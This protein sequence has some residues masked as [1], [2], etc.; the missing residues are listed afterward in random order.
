MT[1]QNTTPQSGNK[2]G[3]PTT[4]NTPVIPSAPS[5]PG[6]PITAST[7]NALGTV[8]NLENEYHRL[9]DNWRLRDQYV[10]QKFIPESLLLAS[11][12]V[13]MTQVKGNQVVMGFLFL[14]CFLFSVV[15]TVSLMKDQY[16]I[17]ATREVIQK[18][19]NKLDIP[20][21]LA[22][23]TLQNP[24]PKPDD[25]KRFNFPEAINIDEDYINHNVQ[26]KNG[27][28]LSLTRLKTFSVIFA[29]QWIM[30]IG[31][32]IIAI[33]AFLNWFK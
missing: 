15:L 28:K 11:A 3:I 25:I 19:A 22:A 4:S 7:P 24:N 20:K 9:C 16:Y 33:G 1:G 12:I 13:G 8:T 2:S 30:T 31:F 32:L 23:I 10:L 17:W 26:K 29:F 18:L 21:D 6:T 14:F 27:K 5:T